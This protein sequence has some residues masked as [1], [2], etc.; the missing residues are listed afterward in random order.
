M[1]AVDTN[2]LV[3]YLTND[4]QVQAQRAYALL[5]RATRVFVAKTV[6]L[7]TEWVLRRVYRLPPSAVL[8]G[9]RQIVGLPNTVVEA[10]EQVARAL[11]YLGQGLDFADGLH[12]AASPGAERCYTFDRRFLRRAVELGLSVEEPEI[13]A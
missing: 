1:I 9:L 4:D 2:V 5:A 7:E 6:L 10:T 3:R 11:H 13:G 12:L 8:A